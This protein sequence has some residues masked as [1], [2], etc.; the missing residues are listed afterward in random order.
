MQNRII[1][2]ICGVCK[3]EHVTIDVINNS[4]SIKLKLLEVEELHT[5]EL[6]KVSDLFSPYFSPAKNVHSY[7]TRGTT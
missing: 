7:E 2:T 1:R 5:F 4:L 3:K 6:S